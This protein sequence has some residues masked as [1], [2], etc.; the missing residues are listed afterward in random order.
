MRG[1]P[2]AP[3][4]SLH[5]P[6]YVYPSAGTGLSIWQSYADLKKKYNVDMFVVMNP[7]NGD[8]DGNYS[9]PD[10]NFIAGKGVMDAAGIRVLGY[11]YT[12]FGERDANEV[13]ARIDTYYNIY[14]GIAGIMFDEMTNNSG[15]EGYYQDLS[16]YVH[17]KGSGQLTVG[18]P[19]TSV[20]SSFTPTMDMIK[21][22][23]GS[24]YPLL[25]TITS[26]T[27]HYADKAKW[28]LTCHALTEFKSKDVVAYADKVKYLFLTNKSG[29]NPY[30]IFSLYADPLASTLGTLNSP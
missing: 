6:L 5:V 8:F 23:E 3:V 9:T 24:G 17:A 1:K 25:S 21:I 29:S 28:G 11:V 14:S 30:N 20:Q 7:S 18:N 15:F 12:L 19:G 2:P 13:K 16:D 10:V 26:R 27:A 4:L 22:Y